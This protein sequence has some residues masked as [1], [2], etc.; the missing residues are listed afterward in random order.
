MRMV[1]KH[2]EWWTKYSAYRVNDKWQLIDIY[3]CCCYSPLT[4]NDNYTVIR[5]YMI[6]CDM[7]KNKSWEY[8]RC[9][10]N[11]EIGQ[12]LSIAKQQW[13]HTSNLWE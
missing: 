12:Q 13:T 11:K 1:D 7:I 10:T 3:H 6:F 5:M 4:N 8:T 2:V 9:K